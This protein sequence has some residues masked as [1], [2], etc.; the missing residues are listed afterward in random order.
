MSVGLRI[1][2]LV[3]LLSRVDI[4]GKIQQNKRKVCSTHVADSNIL[5]KKSNAT[6]YDI[7]REANVSPSMVSR[8][9]NQKPGVSRAKRELI[10]GL[11]K[12]HNYVPDE[13]ARSLKSREQ[14]ASGLLYRMCVILFFHGSCMNAIRLPRKMAI[15]FFHM[16]HT[17]FRKLK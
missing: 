15:L 6:I 8:V 13:F 14:D 16:R 2:A 11:L 4:A 12:K 5:T 7:A 1:S 3:H 9:Y 17:M 10:E